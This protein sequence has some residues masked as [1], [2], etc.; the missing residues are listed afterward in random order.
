[1]GALG[2]PASTLVVGIRDFNEHP[3]ESLDEFETTTIDAMDGNDVDMLRY[4][5]PAKIDPGQAVIVFA[6]TEAT[7]ALVYA[8]L[9]KHHSWKIVM[10]DGS[11]VQ[12][13]GYIK[14]IKPILNKTEDVTYEVTIR[15]TSRGTRNPPTPQTP[16]PSPPPTEEP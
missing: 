4:F 5:E 2:Q 6:A 9:G 1:M 7:V 14:I 3:S 15:R 8:E 13:D 16:P 12:F 10:S 11:Y